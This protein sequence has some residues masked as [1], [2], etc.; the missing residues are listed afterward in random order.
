MSVP[1][2]QRILIAT[3]AAIHIYTAYIWKGKAQHH[4]VQEALRENPQI[5]HSDQLEILALNR[6][7]YRKENMQY[8]IPYRNATKRKPVLKRRKAIPR[9]R[10]CSRQ[11]MENILLARL[12]EASSDRNKTKEQDS[13]Q[14]ANILRLK[15]PRTPPARQHSDDGW[16]HNTTA[17]C[18]TGVS[19]TTYTGVSPPQC[20]CA[21]CVSCMSCMNVCVCLVLSEV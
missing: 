15:K 12:L 1:G 4:L 19:T 18:T 21:W 14:V 6:K 17:L 16:H 3:L 5:N 13:A 9:Q 8:R 2:A 11:L 7:I 20:L 10:H